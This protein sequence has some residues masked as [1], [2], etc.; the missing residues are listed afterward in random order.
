MARAGPMN[1]LRSGVTVGVLTAGGR[2]LGYVRNAAV[3]AFLGAGPEADAFFIAVQIPGFVRRLFAG[4]GV[5]AAFIPMFARRLTRGGPAA[6]RRFA[7]EM[8]STS[9]AALMLITALVA[10]AAPFILQV[11]AP[12]FASDSE[13][14][15]LSGLL[16][17]IMLPFM[18]FASLAQLLGGMLN[19]LGRFAAAASMP[20]VF[21]AVVIAALLFLSPRFETPALAL[22]WGIAA[23]GAVQF[24]CLAAAC[25]RAGMTPA[26]VP[27]QLTP[28]VRRVVRRAGPAVI[29]VVAA[30]A[31]LVT[32]LALASFLPAGSA[33]YLH[34]ADR[35][36]RLLPGIVGAATAT[37]LL[38]YLSRGRRGGRGA[39]AGDATN[40]TIEAVLVLGLP[41]AAA[42]AVIAEPATAAL[43]QRG[44]FTAATT[45]AAAPALAA[46]AAALPAWILIRTLGAVFFARGDTATPMA[47][48]AAAVLVNLALGLLLMGPF[49]HVG[50]A[51][52]TALAA[53]IH[54]LSM[55]AVLVRR[56]WFEP[57][58][59]LRRSVPAVILLSLA[60]AGALWLTRLALGGEP[61]AGELQRVATLGGLLAIGSVCFAAIGLATRTVRLRDL[62]QAWRSGSD[63]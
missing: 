2:L 40:R 62:A 49:S 7:G 5:G 46:Y 25:R 44:A 19:G 45:A 58:A 29:G 33:S 15:A 17:R 51:L 31:I 1:L 23:A 28:G 60:T 22:A 18:L 53:W 50:I 24:A 41:G 39:A 59:R 12:G 10:L 61:A 9:A 47:A 43:F 14:L 36:A 4:R 11:L 6:A 38:P 20:I 54:A 34:Y 56:A 48:A 35:V 13:R 63:A 21:N 3:A 16:V 8:L 55:Y 27:P 37:V 32:D 26:V 42:L 30:Q 52:A 57:D